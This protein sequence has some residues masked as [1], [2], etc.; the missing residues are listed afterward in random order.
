MTEHDRSHPRWVVPPADAA[1]EAPDTLAQADPL[2]A[3]PPPAAAGAPSRRW[4]RAGSRP[5]VRGRARRA[6]VAAAVGLGLLVGGGAA[7]TALA[8]DGGPDGGAA[9]VT[10]RVDGGPP[11]RGDGPGPGD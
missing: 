4:R 5:A 11:D 3:P 6:V 10:D 2:A 8:A 1:P 9:G 7:G